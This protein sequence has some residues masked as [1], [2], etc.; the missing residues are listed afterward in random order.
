MRQRTKFKDVG[1][2]LFTALL[3]LFHIKIVSEFQAASSNLQ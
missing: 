1:L 3:L 2:G